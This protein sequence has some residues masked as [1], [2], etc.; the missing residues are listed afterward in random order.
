MLN[1]ERHVD[2]GRPLLLE[3]PPFL[4]R[5]SFIAAQICPKTYFPLTVFNLLQPQDSF[6]CSAHIA[7]AISKT[8]SHRYL[9]TRRTKGTHVSGASLFYTRVWRVIILQMRVKRFSH[10]WDR[11]VLRSQCSCHCY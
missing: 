6:I 5:T 11:S 4:T 1:F 7:Q 10:A 3:P 8:V 9:N 2:R